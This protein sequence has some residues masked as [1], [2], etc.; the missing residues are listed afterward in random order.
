MAHKSKPSSFSKDYRSVNVVS[1][2]L[3]SSLQKEFKDLTGKTPMEGVNVTV[4]D[5][6]NFFRWEVSFAHTHTPTSRALVHYSSSSSHTWDLSGFRS[7]NSPA[8]SFVRGHND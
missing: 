6:S 2:C 3:S 8:R 5:E 1:N 7:L 4:P